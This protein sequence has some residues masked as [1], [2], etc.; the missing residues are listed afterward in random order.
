MTG[1]KIRILNRKYCTSSNLVDFPLSC[2]IL[3]LTG[4]VVSFRDTY[5]C[6]TILPAIL[7]AEKQPVNRASKSCDQKG[8]HFFFCEAVFAAF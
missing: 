5:F 4:A 8:W 1:W 7:H 2:Y 6:K 3:Q